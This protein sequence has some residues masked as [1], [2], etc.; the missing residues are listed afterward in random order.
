MS[1][2]T[3]SATSSSRDHYMEYYYISHYLVHDASYVFTGLPLVHTCLRN[4]NLINSPREL[5]A[6]EVQK[7]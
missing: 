2:S 1:M 6:Q 3:S 4:I 5:G 7:Q